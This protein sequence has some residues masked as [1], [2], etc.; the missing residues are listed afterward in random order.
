MFLFNLHA[1]PTKSSEHFNEFVGAYVSVY[2]NYADADGAMQLA[3]YY[4]EQ[5]GWVVNNIE[6]D[7]YA[8][9]SAD[10]LEGEQLD[11]FDEA[12]QYGF[13]MVF[14]AYE[15]AEEEE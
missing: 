8:I 4:V 7:Y 3:K 1:V 2:I 6:D 12:E 11:L 14:N 15:T 9:E 5:E 10:E 13:T